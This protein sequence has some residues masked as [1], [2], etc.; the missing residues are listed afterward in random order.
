LRLTEA[1]AEQADG[2]RE[3]FTRNPDKGDAA[4]VSGAWPFRPFI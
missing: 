1:A 2:L 3:H 4:T